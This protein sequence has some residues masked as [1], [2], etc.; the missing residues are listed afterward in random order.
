MMNNKMSRYFQ[1]RK[2]SF[3]QK[4]RMDYYNIGY[5]MIG[6]L[7]NYPLPPASLVDLVIGTKEI[8]WYQLGGLFMAQAITTFLKRNGKDVNAFHSMLDFGCGCGR[9]LRWWAALHDQCEI[10]GSD[11]N[12]DLIDWCQKNLSSI[13]KFEV[14]HSDPPLDFPNEK[15]DFV[16]A[17]SVFTHF[18]VKKQQPWLREMVRVL[19]PGGILLLTLHGRR[20]AWRMGFSP[21]QFKQLEENGIM[22]FGEE[23][24]GLNACS[25]YHSFEFMKNQQEIGLELIDFM[26]GGVRDTSEQDM[27]LYRKI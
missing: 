19:K 23:K 10:W 20:V 15:F 14:N 3:Q 12:P 18:L 17:Y 11:Y 25:A 21:E 16:Y 5:K 2:I 22:V 9:I 4:F 27:Y 26:E 7:D 1:R 13:A 8:A 6:S 24:D